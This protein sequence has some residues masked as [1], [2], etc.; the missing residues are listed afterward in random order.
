MMP[1]SSHLPA[2]LS[3]ALARL[4]L[5]QPGASHSHSS[6]MAQVRQDV[7]QTWSQILTDL[8]HTLGF[9]AQST[10]ESLMQGIMSWGMRLFAAIIFIIIAWFLALW[11]RRLVSRA[12]GRAE[13]DPTVA[14]FVANLSRWTLLVIAGVACLGIFGV[15]TTSF[16][17]VLGSVGV[18]VG[19]ALQGSL[20][21]FAAGIMLLLF[22]P[23]QVG[24]SVIIA[25]QTGTVDEIE[26]FSTQ[27]DTP[28][29]RRIIIPNSQIF[30][31][32]IE[33]RS[34][35]DT[36]LVQFR[37]S[38]DPA[39]DIERTRAVLTA[40]ALAN[41]HRLTDRD[42]AVSIAALGAGV[43]WNVGIWTKRE[44]FGPAEQELLRTVRESLS[45]EGINAPTPTQNVN[46][47]V[48]QLA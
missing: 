9:N 15:E 23:F 8:L 30:G 1:L 42:P 6:A 13:A 21:N 18:A 17:A 14:K 41:S 12:M 46:Q 27:L 47:Y 36:R 25:G 37:V 38:V 33:N 31:S 34:F 10:R 43:D 2:E 7:S 20:S 19:L 5:A 44:T 28:D 16:I 24:D 26:L 35:N 45:R 3:A 11:V 39:T 48:K 22:R 4:A 29:N 40:A 32:I